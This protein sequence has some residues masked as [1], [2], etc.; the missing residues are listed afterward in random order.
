[1]IEVF[2]I[3]AVKQ[4]TNQNESAYYPGIATSGSSTHNQFNVQQ[5]TPCKECIGRIEFC[6]M[7]IVEI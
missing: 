6:L 7:Y 2:T 1:M 4:R 5:E 3:E